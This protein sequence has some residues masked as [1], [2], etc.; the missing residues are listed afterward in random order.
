MLSVDSNYDV[1]LDS[2]NKEIVELGRVISSVSLDHLE[3]ATH[4]VAI[5]ISDCFLHTIPD[6]DVNIALKDFFY[7]LSR[8][9]SLNVKQIQREVYSIVNNKKQHKECSL[10]ADYVMESNSFLEVLLK[11]E[12]VLSNIDYELINSNYNT[13]KYI[14]DITNKAIKPYLLRIK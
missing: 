14:V 9:T 12:Y 6:D 10:L 11:K 13:F 4:A 8:T 2:N 3:L 1:V 7:I 5:C